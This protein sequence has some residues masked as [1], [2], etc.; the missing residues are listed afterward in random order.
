MKIGKFKEPKDGDTLMKYF[1]MSEV[2]VAI[3][4]MIVLIASITF[5]ENGIV[6][7]CKLRLQIKKKQSEIQGLVL[8]NYELSKKINA[9]KKED[10]FTLEKI[11]REK[12]MLIKPGEIVYLLPSED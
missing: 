11:A 12:L 1:L 10:E 5:G 3:I 7:Y 9:L 6:N 2:L 8:K 4:I